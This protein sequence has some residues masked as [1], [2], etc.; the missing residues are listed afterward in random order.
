MMYL[1]GV[2]PAI[3]YSFSGYASVWYCGHHRKVQ[4]PFAAISLEVLVVRDFALFPPSV[5]ISSMEVNF[6][7]RR[8]LCEIRPGRRPW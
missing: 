6:A 2:D 3:F 8:R 1:F 4:S 5:D 7:C